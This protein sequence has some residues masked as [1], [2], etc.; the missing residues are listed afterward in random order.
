[1]IE[2]LK[3]T[4]EFMLSDDHVKRLAA[5]YQQLQYRLAKLYDTI[6]L[7]NTHQLEYPLDCDIDILETQADAMSMYLDCLAERLAAYLDDD[8]DCEDCD[9]AK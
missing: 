7:F 4:V 8:C 9:H 6:K 1:M 5:E 2:N 3:E